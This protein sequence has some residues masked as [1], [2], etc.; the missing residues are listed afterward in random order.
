MIPLTDETCAATI[1]G[2]SSALLLCIKKLCPHCKNMEK[3]VEKFAA[4]EPGLELFSLDT[5]ECMKTAASLDALRAPTLLVIKNGKAVVTKAGL[6][7]PR[8]LRALFDG[9]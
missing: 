8:E 4:T 2:A 6:M 5:E 1:A 3:V 7:N 9:A